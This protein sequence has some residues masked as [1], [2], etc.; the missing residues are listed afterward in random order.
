MSIFYYHLLP[1]SVSVVYKYIRIGNWKRVTVLLL[2]LYLL[3]YPFRICQ[4]KKRFLR[5]YNI[6][7][8]LFLLSADYFQKTKITKRFFCN[9]YFFFI[10]ENN[11]L[12][13]QISKCTTMII[14]SIHNIFSSIF[15][16]H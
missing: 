16:I 11:I 3:K 15:M 4:S 13:F 5:F 2:K 9:I 7:V 10:L 6:K 8:L 1:A 12:C 14:L